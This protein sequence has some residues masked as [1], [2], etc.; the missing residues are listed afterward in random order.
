MHRFTGRTSFVLLS[1]LI[2]VLVQPGLA[3]D[4]TIVSQE[5]VAPEVAKALLEQVRSDVTVVQRP[6]AS[7]IA[8]WHGGTWEADPSANLPHQPENMSLV[9]AELDEQDY[10]DIE[11]SLL[12]PWEHAWEMRA[13]TRFFLLVA[14]DY[15][16]P[17]W[18][19]SLPAPWRSD[20]QIDE[21]RWSSEHGHS[22][23]TRTDQFRSLN[24]YLHGFERIADANIETFVYKSVGAMRNPTTLAMDEVE[25]LVRLDVRGIDD[26]GALRNDRGMLRVFASRSDDDSWA[27]DRVA[28]GKMETLKTDGALFEDVTD[29]A[30]LASLPVYTR[31]EAIRRGGYA[32]S[33][34]DFD[35]DDHQDLYVGG[36][37]TSTLL[38]GDGAGTFEKVG[39]T[40]VEENTLVKSAIF[41]DFFNA[42]REDLLVVRFEPSLD[43]RD[44][45]IV[46][47][48]NAGDGTFDKIDAPIEGYK[49]LMY[50]MPATAADYDADGYLDF[51]V[52]FPGRHDFTVPNGAGMTASFA[53]VQ[54]LFLNDR[55]SRFTDHTGPSNLYEDGASSQLLYPH[56]ALS[57]DYDQDGDMDLVVI[58]DRGN[59]SPLYENDG[60]GV[61]S[62]ASSKIGISNRDYG[63]GAAIGDI[64]NDG[65][66]DFVLSNVNF[67]AS[68]RI[69]DSSMIHYNAEYLDRGIRGLRMFM[70]TGSGRFVE[71]TNVSG[72]DWAGEGL[73]CIE[74]VDYNNDG[75]LDLYVANGL[76]SGT[77]ESQDLG[78]LFVRHTRREGRQ[79]IRTPLMRWAGEQDRSVIMKVL[80]GFEGDIHDLASNVDERPGLA[81]LQRNRLFRNDGEGQFTEV[82]FL[83]GV[84]ATSDGYTVA[85]SDIDEDGDM[86][87]VIRNCD[88]G[89]VDVNYPTVQV[90]RNLNTDGHS[91]RLRLE[92][93]TSNKD[94]IGA[95]VIARTGDQELLRHL[96]A[97]NGTV[98]SEKVI[99]FGLGDVASVDELTIKWPNGA[100][101]VLHN[102]PAGDL[103]VVEDSRYAETEDSTPTPTGSW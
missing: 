44:R 20:G 10:I 90:F 21:I 1:L 55:T 24:R 81:G 46:F 33:I 15:V 66:L 64:D 89:S 53:P 51:Y 34:A 84:D 98:Q 25:L 18:D 6:N 56:S 4:G 57:L 76:W 37:G 49:N 74:F 83:A 71:T 69:N 36:W 13:A 93:T 59:L 102:V 17:A 91:L 35:N 85:T 94:G 11:Q 7:S 2:P 58:D 31:S 88:P 19:A 30:G 41:G 22:L 100:V 97:N 32:L 77:D 48:R 65:H 62:S 79:D 67:L 39:V 63:M 61:F 3:S 95:L 103:L 99:H 27:L 72:L 82:G 52:G 96:I 92:G 26:S 87:L 42:G 14:D 86:D 16:S 80:S 40:N 28:I 12:I 9:L 29:E 47:Y 38:R 73:A 101:Q 5:I 70:G 68:R 45:E 23:N 78:S 8:S 75:L 43:K 54:G 60:T 50:A